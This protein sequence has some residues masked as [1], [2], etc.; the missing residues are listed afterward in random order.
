MKYRHLLISFGLMGVAL[1]AYA[2][3]KVREPNTP[4]LSTVWVGWADSMHYFRIQLAADGTG[5][6]SFYERSRSSSRLYE[7]TKWTLKGY[8][9]ELTLKPI[10]ADAWPV[11]MKGTATPSRLYLKLGDGRKN[12]WRAEATFEHEKFIESAM[13]SA[14]KRMLDYKK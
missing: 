12:G 8:D 10:D 4:E 13:E 2:N 6:C 3:T 14:K 1:L 11:T 5:L 7:V 9:I